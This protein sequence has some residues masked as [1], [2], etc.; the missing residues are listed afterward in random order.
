MAVFDILSVTDREITSQ[1][2]IKNEIM[3]SG[4]CIKHTTGAS[5]AV[6]RLSTVI[7]LISALSFF[8]WNIS[9]LASWSS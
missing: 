2:L 7:T 8:I 9:S 4:E 1:D 6:R 5:L 3:E